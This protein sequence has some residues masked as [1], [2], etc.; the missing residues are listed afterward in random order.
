MRST[1]WEDNSQLGSW[2][3]IKSISR[4]EMVLR[5]GDK[6]PETYILRRIPE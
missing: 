3:E 1:A 6:A 5:T 4:D 2:F